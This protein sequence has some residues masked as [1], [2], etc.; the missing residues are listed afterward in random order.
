MTEAGTRGP[1]RG[2]LLPLLLAAL[3]CACSTN[4]VSVREIGAREAFADR[5][6]SAAGG[7]RLSLPSENMLRALGEERLLQAK[8]E[9]AL[10][11]LTPLPAPEPGKSLLLAELLCL[12]AQHRLDREAAP[13]F[14]EAALVALRAL[15]G[16]WPVDPAFDPRFAF[17]QDLY[18]YAGTEFFLRMRRGSGPLAGWTVLES[19]SGRYEVERREPKEGEWDPAFFDDLLPSVPFLIRG[20]R[21]RHER[22]GLGVPLIAIREGFPARQEAYYPPEGRV[23]PATFLLLPGAREGTLAIVLANPWRARTWD[24]GGR[25]VPIAADLTAPYAHALARAR[26]H[27]LGDTAFFDPDAARWH[28]GL[29][30]LE[31]YDPGKIPVVL[32][33]G[34][35]SS[36]LKWRDLTNEIWGEDGLRARFQVWHYTY[37]TGAPVLNNARDLREALVRV[38]KDLDPEGDDPA[39]E[40]LVL[41]GHS[42]G[43]V[44]V[45]TLVQDS[46]ESLWNARFA[47]PLSTLDLSE[48]G[49]RYAERTFFFEALPF[50][51]RAI[52]LAAPHRGSAEADSIIG[53]VGDL[54]LTHP[55]RVSDF[56]SEVE[57]RNPGAMRPGPIAAPSSVDV[58][59]PSHVVLRALAQLPIA[60]WVTY[61][62]I[63]G[64]RTRKMGPGGTD[65]IVPYESAHLEGA[66]SEL[67]VEGRHDIHEHPKAIAEVLRILR[68]HASRAP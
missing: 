20:F 46:G 60:P 37:P 65:G 51:H 11:A 9:E 31:P 64:D 61:H 18:D 47:K 38:R 39:M 58:L 44:L 32:V 40:D 29:F 23:Y 6:R 48:E 43:G 1:R 33:H 49:R 17:L 30:L 13:A 54:L 22:P 52:F 8:P 45:K 67:V 66:A 19:L 59:S 14:L 16:P 27:A 3:A 56:A 7:D 68:E 25:T 55:R 5:G 28:Q 24:V 21:A 2:G 62:S 10:A 12:R 50:V 26:L 57:K 15:L 34:L 36:P 53:W 63:L 41:V 35:W 4:P 42:L